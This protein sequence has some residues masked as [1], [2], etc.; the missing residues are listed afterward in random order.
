MQVKARLGWRAFFGSDPYPFDL[1]MVERRDNTDEQGRF[2]V[3][4]LPAPPAVVLDAGCGSG[5]HVRALSSAGHRAM[6]VDLYIA[7]SAVR[8]SA[9]TLL[10][11]G[12]M[13]YLPLGDRSVDAVISMYSSVGYETPLMVTFREWR[14]VTRDG[15]T[16]ILDLAGPANGARVFRERTRDGWAVGVRLR[17]GSRFY[18]SNLARRSTGLELFG[19]SYPAADLV[20]VTLELEAAGWTVQRCYGDYRGGPSTRTSPRLLVVACNDG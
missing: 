10:V 8:Q 3:A 13:H 9:G 12:D 6:G 15:G 4:Q 20:A 16:L 7:Q 2:L 19:F 14:R 5:R 17:I 18:Q 1:A 11:R